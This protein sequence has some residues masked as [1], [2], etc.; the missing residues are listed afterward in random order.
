M[1]NSDP[2]FEDKVFKAHSNDRA[3]NTAKITDKLDELK[4]TETQ[5]TAQEAMSAFV[6]MLKGDKGD[7]GDDGG[8]PTQEELLSLIEPLIPEPIPG[9]KG[10][11]GK[12]Y[13]LTSKDKQ[14]IVSKIEVPIV[15]KIIEK[16]EVIREQPIVKEV[17]VRDTGLEVAKKLTELKGEDRLDVES[18]KGLDRVE[19]NFLN[20][21]KGF[22]SK[23]L[24]GQADVNI[25]N[26]TDGQVLTYNKKTN[27][28][29]ASTGSG[30]GIVQ[31]IVAG[32]G[33]SVN[34][35]DPA[36]PIITNTGTAP[37]F[38]D[39]E[40]VNGSG[41]SFTL[42]N[43]PIAGSVHLYGQRNR[44]TPG[45][46]NDYTISGTTITTTLSYATGDLLADYRK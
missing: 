13:V 11:D 24:A 38:I 2:K 23:T 40:I 36:N 20:Q 8:K 41:T 17:A 5:K 43:T 33:I 18:L 7:K 3:K 12:N 10:D 16:T 42:A 9:D 30:S 21:A 34:S 29:I 37:S 39:N 25:P 14:E 32:T 26:P 27:K 6:Q 45:A 46:G 22:V 1:P 4:P 19:A 28:W 15:E 31:T 44:L 35:T